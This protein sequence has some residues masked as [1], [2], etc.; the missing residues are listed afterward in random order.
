MSQYI[1]SGFSGVVGAILTAIGSY[2]FYRIRQKKQQNVTKF[3]LYMVINQMKNDIDKAYERL[4]ENDMY[5]ISPLFVY[6]GAYNY[7]ENLCELKG[8]LSLE[9]IQV[10]NQFF[11]DVK[12]FDNIRAS[13]NNSLSILNSGQGSFAPDFYQNTQ[14]NYQ[15]LLSKYAE[16]LQKFKKDNYYQ[17]KLILILDKLK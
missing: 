8:T 9:E 12:S 10:V 7:I 17:G 1:I 13:A 6:D 2:L 11:E 14:R 15:L 16:K 5:L 3:H 4:I